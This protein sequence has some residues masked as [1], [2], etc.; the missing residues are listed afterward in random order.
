[1]DAMLLPLLAKID[2]QYALLVVWA[3]SATTLNVKLVFALSEAHRRF[4]SFVGELASFNARNEHRMA[5]PDG[6]SDE[7]S[8]RAGRNRPAG[9]TD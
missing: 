6:A 2:A 1:M 3:L 8:P 5:L 9:T 4:E 7:G